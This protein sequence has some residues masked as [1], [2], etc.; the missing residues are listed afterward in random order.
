MRITQQW[1]KA[2]GFHTHIGSVGIFLTV[3]LVFCTSGCSEKRF[4]KQ[5]FYSLL[6]RFYGMV[7]GFL[8]TQAAVS[9]WVMLS[10]VSFEGFFHCS[11]RL[12]TIPLLNPKQWLWGTIERL[13]HIP[14]TLKNNLKVQRSWQRWCF[15]SA[16]W[17]RLLN[18]IFFVIV[19][20]QIWYF[21]K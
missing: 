13:V 21:W 10:Y 2:S 5:F 17:H 12:V 3:P 4:R 14:L 1:W 18:L 8:Q 7:L 9:A 20:P 15:H 16:S 6:F 19:N 11:L